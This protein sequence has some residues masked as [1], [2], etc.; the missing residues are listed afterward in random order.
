ML[1]I[2]NYIFHCFQFPF[3]PLLPYAIIPINEA[4]PLFIINYYYSDLLLTNYI[5]C[6]FFRKYFCI[7]WSWRICCCVLNSQFP[8]IFFKHYL[9]ISFVTIKKITINLIVAFL[10]K[11]SHHVWN[12]LRYYIFENCFYFLSSPLGAWIACTFD[13]PFVSLNLLYFYVFS[14]YVFL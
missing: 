3:N 13:L 12:S 4:Q 7:I 5:S 9:L 11:L 6:G 8:V 10:K 14:S 1:T 2:T